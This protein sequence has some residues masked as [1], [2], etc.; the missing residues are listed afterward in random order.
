M[1]SCSVVEV[2]ASVKESS[3]NRAKDQAGLVTYP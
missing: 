2:L 1:C 3:P